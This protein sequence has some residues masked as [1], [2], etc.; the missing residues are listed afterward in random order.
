MNQPWPT[1][2]RHCL[3]AAIRLFPVNFSARCASWDRRTQPVY[4]GEALADTSYFFALP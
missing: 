2:S 1:C 4:N 3:E